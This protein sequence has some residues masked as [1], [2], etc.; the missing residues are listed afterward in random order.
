M[1]SR[2]FLDRP[3]ILDASACRPRALAAVSKTRI[4]GQMDLYLRKVI[5]P[6][7]SRTH[8]LI[9]MSARR[10]MA[11]TLLGFV[12]LDGYILGWVDRAGL[13][14][15]SGLKDQSRQARA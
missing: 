11:A 6:Q 2:Q 8:F 15:H 12:A 1:R 9:P 3:L 14:R 7:S 13:S 10:D 4:S 5:H